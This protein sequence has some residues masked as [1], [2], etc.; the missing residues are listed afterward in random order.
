MINYYGKQRQFKL[1]LAAFG[2][3]LIFVLNVNNNSAQKNF[4]SEA[5]VKFENEAYFT[6][7]DLYKKGEVKEKDIREKG[8]IN[9]QLAEC[10]RYSVEPAQAQTYYQRAIKLKFQE[11]NQEIFLLLADVLKEQGEY[12][13]ALENINKF[14]ELNPEDKKASDALVSCKKAIEWKE[15]PTKHMIQN[16]ILINSD[17]YDFAPTWGDKK[18]DVLIFASAREGST[19]DGIDARTGESFMDLWSTTRDNNGK[20]SEPQLLPNSINTKDN[21][22]PAVM[23]KK[24]DKIFFTRCP[25]EKKINL[26]C[27]IFEA[28]KKGNS[29][30]QAEKIQLKPDG[31][32]TL[33]CGHPAINSTMRF[34]I[35]SADFPGGYGG[36]DLWI[37]EYDKREDSWMSPTNLGSTVN[38]EGDEMFPYLAEDNSL[39][40]S[41]NG[42]VGLG[43]LDVFKAVN[44]GDKTW[45][46]PVNLQW[47]INSPEHDFGIIFE[48]GTDKRGYI[49][50][51]REDLGGKGKDDLY[52]FNLP[53]IQFSLSVFVSNKETNE[54][55]PGVTIKVTGIDT[56]TAGGI[57]S[58][59]VQTTDGEGKAIFEEISKGKRYILKEMIYEIEVEKDSFLVA[60]NQISTINEENSKRFLEE[61]YL[62][63]IVDESGEAA[64][65]DFPEVQYALDK[66]ELLVDDN[67]N[68]EDSLDFLYTTLTDNPNIVIEL[69]AHTDCRGSDKYNKKLSQRRAQ[70]C[71][72]YLISKGIPKERMVPVGYGEDRPRMEGLECGSIDRLST[73]EEQEA[74][75][76]K[77]RRTQF[78][79]LSTDYSPGLDE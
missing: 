60:R 18:H 77:N 30:T 42:Y 54:Q 48:R 75:H 5:D 9:F 68:S 11:E 35:F 25:R 26:G 63:P 24:G 49:T 50:S 12:Q 43:G 3:F 19:G 71:V 17:H 76:Q 57:V 39:Y 14:L 33:S 10:Y 58:E 20:W 23:S 64:I 46:E 40:F 65:I 69:Q 59:Y 52:N 72:D 44:T 67:V 7:I 6:A 45:G 31:A 4:V 73:K 55:I 32:D 1:N 51:S 2:L 8:R 47:P 27:E 16:E 34:M 79:V 28:E 29:W 61:V 56:S 22:G 37:S 66:A 62:I 13:S 70:S 53:E 36:K 38:T 41:S 15:N 78:I 74:A 21:E